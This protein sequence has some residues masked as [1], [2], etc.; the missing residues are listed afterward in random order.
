M[1]LKCPTCGLN[2]EKLEHYTEE[3]SKMDK[4]KMG[5]S[6]LVEK[7]LA[8]RDTKFSLYLCKYCKTLCKVK[9]SKYRAGT[10]ITIEYG[11][12]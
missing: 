9:V 6:L 5:E 2:I 3:I 10:I 1:K 12:D 7:E 11:Q 4:Y 8:G